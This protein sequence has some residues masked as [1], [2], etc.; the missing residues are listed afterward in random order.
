MVIYG[1]TAGSYTAHANIP[2]TSLNHVYLY[3]KLKDENKFDLV[4]CDEKLRNFLCRNK[5]AKI[6]VTVI[7]NNGKI[8]TGTLYWWH[9]E[10]NMQHGIV[11]KHDETNENLYAASQYKNKVPFIL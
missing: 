1:L 11:C 7:L 6:K 5:E 4:G 3:G 10:K 2:Y 8:Y 9:D